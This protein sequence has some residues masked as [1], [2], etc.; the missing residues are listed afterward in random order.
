MLTNSSAFLTSFI[1]FKNVFRDSLH[2]FDN[3]GYGSVFDGEFGGGD[4][5]NLSTQAVL[6]LIKNVSVDDQVEP[7]F[8]LIEADEI[9][10]HQIPRLEGIG[11]ETSLGKV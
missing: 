6:S 2:G 4:F 3:R 7:G 10:E 9:Q 11:Q 5:S 1:V 8:V